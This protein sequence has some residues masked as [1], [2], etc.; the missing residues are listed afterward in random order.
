MLILS[1]VNSCSSENV[2]R[3]K[4][5]TMGLHFLLYPSEYVNKKNELNSDSFYQLRT[6]KVHREKI[7]FG[8]K[9]ISVFQ[10]KFQSSKLLRKAIEEWSNNIYSMWNLALMQ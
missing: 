8:N 2:D 9:E 10:V 4:D 5:L 6:G 7:Q 1:A 3:I